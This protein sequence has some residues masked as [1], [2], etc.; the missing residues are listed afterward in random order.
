MTKTLSLIQAAVVKAALAVTTVGVVAVPLM[1]TSAHAAAVSQADATKS[2]NRLLGNV[3]SMS[4]NFS[5][6]TRAGNKTSNFS[7]TMSV[8]RPNQFRWE[9]KSPAEQLIVANGSTLW[10]YDKDLQQVT[11]QSVNN[12][13]GETPAL[14]LSGDVNQINRSFSVSQPYSNKNYFV[15]TPKSANANFKNVSISF[16][17]GRPVMMVLNDNLGQETSIRFSNITMNKKIAASQFDFKPPA[18]VDVISQ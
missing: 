8:Q 18:G 9:T 14:L 11:K 1:T 13:V 7:G 15:L 10:I 12:Q 2:L 6:K 16:N 5:Q 3:K 17:G 4:A